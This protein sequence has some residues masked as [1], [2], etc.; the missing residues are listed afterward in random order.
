M[1][2]IYT[3]IYREYYVPST[4]MMTYITVLPFYIYNYRHEYRL[5]KQF[6]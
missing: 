3:F 1:G 5:I 6:T 2:N 4:Q